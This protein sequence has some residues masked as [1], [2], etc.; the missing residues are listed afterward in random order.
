MQVIQRTTAIQLQKVLAG[1]QCEASSYTVGGGQSGN[2]TVFSC[3]YDSASVV[4]QR[5]CTFPGHVNE[6][7]VVTC[8]YTSCFWG[9]LLIWDTRLV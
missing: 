6:D 1:V 4:T 9:P 8:V 5:N 7:R 3:Q 2:E